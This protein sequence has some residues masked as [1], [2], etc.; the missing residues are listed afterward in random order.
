[1]SAPSLPVIYRVDVDVRELAYLALQ[2][3]A[4][5]RLASGLPSAIGPENNA[6]LHELI[7]AAQKFSVDS[8]NELLAKLHKLLES[9]LSDS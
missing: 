2:V 6:A 4:I 1:M 3:D 8:Q 9:Q 5:G 7:T